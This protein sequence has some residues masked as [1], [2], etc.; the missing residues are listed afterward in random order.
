MTDDRWSMVDGR[1][2]MVDG[3]WPPMIDGRW[4]M[5]DEDAE[6]GG[7]RLEVGGWR[8]G[9]WRLEGATN[10][11]GSSSVGSYR[12]CWKPVGSGSSSRITYGNGPR[13]RTR[14]TYTALAVALVSVAILV[15]RRLV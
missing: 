15:M 5:V 14:L 1:W 10:S 9:R 7:W 12:C 8:L 13:R 3:R 2:S 6:V 11:L 4:P